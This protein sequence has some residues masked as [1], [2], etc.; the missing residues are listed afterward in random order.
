[1]N[2]QS[3]QT[4]IE[5]II[6]VGLMVLVFTSLAAGITL[7]IRN[8]RYARNQTLSKDY[9][10]EELEF[11]RSMR[12]QMGWESF[13]ASTKVGTYC[14]Q[15]LPTTP[16]A[17]AAKAIGACSSTQ[18]ISGTP[19]MRELTI[20]KSGAPTNLI[21]A[22]AVVSWIEGSKSFDANSRLELRQ[23]TR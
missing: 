17:Y 12:D 7:S 19:F 3:G 9:V 2:R 10:R 16:T 13:A 15:T 8:N 21:T 11:L 4:L 23:W 6:A 22:T 5:V 20:V 18:T 1:M 14:F